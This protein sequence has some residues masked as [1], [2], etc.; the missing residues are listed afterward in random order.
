MITR[1]SY[2]AFITSR[3]YPFCN[4]FI[5]PSVL[6]S[7]F[8]LYP[9][10]FLFCNICSFVLLLDST[11]K[12]NHTVLLFLCLISLTITA[13]G[14]T[15][16]VTNEKISSF[17]CTRASQVV[18]VNA[19]EIRDMGSI[20]GSGR[21][22]GGGT[23]N[24]LQYSCLENPMDREAWKA[25]IHGVAKSWTWLRDFTYFTKSQL[26]Y[27]HNNKMCILTNLIWIWCAH[28]VTYIANL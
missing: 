8:S 11:Y 13:S 4:L 20:P 17:F 27:R 2:L 14:S 24:P 18:L 12:G 23:G 22:P 5:P 21:F 15:H 28:L 19:G 7:V 1:I 25:T 10:V 16:V 26:V 6:P 9:W 3:G